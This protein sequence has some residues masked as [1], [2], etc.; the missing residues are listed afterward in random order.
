MEL[1]AS[2]YPAS[3][4]DLVLRS[5]VFAPPDGG[6]VVLQNS[7]KDKGA[8]NSLSESWR[9]P[10]EGW[11]VETGVPF[12]REGGGPRVEGRRRLPRAGGWLSGLRGLGSRPAEAWQWRGLWLA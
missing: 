2:R 8:E 1:L 12:G 9:I 10:R 3:L 4:G 6:G 11:G 5:L 7:S